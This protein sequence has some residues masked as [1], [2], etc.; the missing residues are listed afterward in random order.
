MSPLQR[1][2]P[3]STRSDPHSPLLRFTFPVD[4]VLQF[5]SICTFVI[6][7]L[8]VFICTMVSC[9]LKVGVVYPSSS[10]YLSSWAG[11]WY[12]TEVSTHVVEHSLE[13]N[14][15]LIP[16]IW[17]IPN[18]WIHR[19]WNQTGGC[20]E[21]AGQG[22]GGGGGIILGEWKCFGTWQ[23]W[24]VFSMMKVLSASELTLLK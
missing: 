22:R 1:S 4:S 16:C 11:A 20:Q 7:E 14:C 24:W 17:N 21:R 15:S 6:R 23:R 3:S 9:P 10:S 13:W 8:I 12:T 5:C 18:R 19:D 2:P